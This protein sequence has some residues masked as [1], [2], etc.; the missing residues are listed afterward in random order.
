MDNR[1]EMIKQLILLKYKSF[2]EFAKSIDM[3]QST[4]MSALNNDIGG[5]SINNFIKICHALGV[6]ADDLAFER[7]DNILTPE[8]QELV[9]NAKHLSTEQL[10]KLI[11]FINSV[12]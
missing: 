5:M 3:P 10:Q 12:K 4:L 8:L 6:S 1:T 9:N 7:Y 11:E 2:R